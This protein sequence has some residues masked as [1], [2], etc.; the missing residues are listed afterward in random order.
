MNGIDDNIRDYHER[1][2]KGLVKK[3]PDFVNLVEQ[4][5][6]ILADG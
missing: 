1:V 4:T 6:Q 5:M 2:R 3:P